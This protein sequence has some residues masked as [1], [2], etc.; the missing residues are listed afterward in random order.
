MRHLRALQ[1][2]AGGVVMAFDEDSRDYE[3][4]YMHAALDRL[5]ALLGNPEYDGRTIDEHFKEQLATLRAEVSAAEEG[6]VE[7]RDAYWEMK[8]ERDRLARA[9]RSIAIG[10]EANMNSVVMSQ[11]ARAALR[12]E[13]ER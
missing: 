4:D 9:L 2:E 3:N 7:M 5:W 6:R 12:E 1:G 13:G 11:I 8:R 10:R